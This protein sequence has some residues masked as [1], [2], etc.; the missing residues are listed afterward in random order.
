MSKQLG[1]SKVPGARTEVGHTVRG[2][3]DV[4]VSRNVAVKPLVMSLEAQEVRRGTSGGGGSFTEPVDVCLVVGTGPDGAF[5]NVGALGDDVVVRDVATEFEV[6]VID[7]TAGVV[8]GDDVLLDE[9]GE[10]MAP[11]KRL[12]VV[13][14]G[15]AVDGEE[16]NASHSGAGGVAGADDG[17]YARWDEFRDSSGP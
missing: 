11:Q 4:V 10:G 13:V 14:A 3:R 16:E 2:A 17:G 6:T 7:G 5:S 1:V 9:F 15:G 8:K 12:D